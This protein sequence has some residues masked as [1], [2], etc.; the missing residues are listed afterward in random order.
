MVAKNTKKYI[1]DKKTHGLYGWESFSHPGET[2]KDEI[3]FLGLTQAEAAART[4]CTIQTISRIVNEKESISPNMALRLERVFGGRPNAEFWL[5]MQSAY[6]HK[7]AM[8]KEA[9]KAEREINFFKTHLKE[10]YK[11]LQKMGLLEKTVLRTVDNFKKAVL[12]IKFF[13]EASTLNS[14]HDENI[15]G[16]AFRK[17]DRKNLNQYNLASLLKIGEIK[18][19]KVLKEPSLKGY[20]EA[21]F[22][23]DL[24][25]LK[26]LTK[27]EPAVFLDELR[28]ICLALGV[29]VVYVPN[30]AHTHFG[31]ASTWLGNHPVIILRVKKQWEDTFWFNFFHEAGHIIKH[32][33]KEFFVD[34]ENGSKTKIEIEADN[35]AQKM[36]I[37]NFE[38]ITTKLKKAI[39]IE[40]WLKESA[41]SANVSQNIIAGRVCNNIGSK[42]A[43]QILSRFRPTIKVKVE[44]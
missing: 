2:L 34:F 39:K 4:G 8:A 13:F 38:E 10:T 7:I 41:E 21:R 27:K 18:A 35:F 32:S 22:L 6:D 12:S 19:R 9:E 23:A 42:K 15:L 24:P 25:K 44:L 28:D 29:M 30:M 3:E 16:V 1:E 33:K 14:I 43:W 36:L 37:P 17:Y 20:D 11:E 31:G 26:S 40:S 5:N